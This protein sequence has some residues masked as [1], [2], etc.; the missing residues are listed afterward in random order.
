[1]KPSLLLVLVSSLVLGAACSS[2]KKSSEEGSTAVK[3]SD[4]ESMIDD[5]KVSFARKQL[6]ELDK[7]L[8]S[9]D[10]G[11]ASSTCAVIE[12]D[13]PA[14]EKADSKLAETLKARCG[15][16]LAVRSLARF[17]EKA[18]AAHAKDPTDTFS[19]EC[20]SYPIYMKP[21][22]AAGVAA[23][24]AEVAKIKARYDVVCPPK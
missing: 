17:V 5:A 24:D 18:E 2:E 12:V 9:D 20:S 4:T 3:G 11:A 10:P 1:M 8:A 23:D 21:V 13:F 6:A 14:I 19:K 7:L 15:R 22:T 16:D